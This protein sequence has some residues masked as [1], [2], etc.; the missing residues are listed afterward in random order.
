MNSIFDSGSIVK[1]VRRRFVHYKIWSC[2]LFSLFP[3]LSSAQQEYRLFFSPPEGDNLIYMMNTSVQAEG[4]DLTGKDISPALTAVGS[5]SLAMKRKAGTHVVMGLS[6]PEIQVE[7]RT[8]EGHQSRSLKTESDETL[9]ATFDLRGRLHKIQNL[10]ARNRQ[11]VM[12]DSLFRILRD[13]FPV[14]PGTP[15]SIGDV[16]TEKRRVKIPY[17]EIDV[18]VFIETTYTLQNVVPSASGDVAVIS[19]NYEVALSGSKNL[20]ELSGRF[21]GKGTGGGLLNFIIQ[22]G[23]I[24]EFRADHQTTATFI[25]QKEEETLMEWPF[26]FSFLASAVLTN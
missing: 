9:Q 19:M 13:V 20:G 6:T 23:C 18:D 10:E 7:V 11:K 25:V 26:H 8:P 12:N 24:Q 15:V 5:I 16:W 4:K 17:Q 3:A 22:R 14:L 2:I 21:E 1:N